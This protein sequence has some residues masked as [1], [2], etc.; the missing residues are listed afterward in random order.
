MIIETGH[1]LYNELLTSFISMIISYFLCYEDLLDCK[2][3]ITKLLDYSNVFIVI[4]NILT[5]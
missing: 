2:A 1:V 4:I 5:G 3:A